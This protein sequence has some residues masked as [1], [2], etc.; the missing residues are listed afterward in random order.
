MSKVEYTAKRALDV[1]NRFA[2]RKLEEQLDRCVRAINEASMEGRTNT[3][4]DIVE[5]AK[6]CGD[7][8][9]AAGYLVEATGNGLKIDWS[10]G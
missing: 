4:V 5:L 10:N 6:E 8:L 7:E 9:A 3:N 2:D 1:S